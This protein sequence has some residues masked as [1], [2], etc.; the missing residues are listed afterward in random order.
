MS[1]RSVGDNVERNRSSANLF[2][3][4]DTLISDSELDQQLSPSSLKEI[5]KH[6][7]KPFDN[8][9]TCFNQSCRKQ[10]TTLER[11]HHCRRCGGIFCSSCL[12]FSRRLNKLAK[13]DPDGEW[14]KVCK[15][16][17]ELGQLT[18]GQTRCHTADFC[19]LRTEFKRWAAAEDTLKSLSWRSKLDIDRECQRL[20][21]GFEKNVGHSELKRTLHGVKSFVTT[22][23]WMKSSTW[24]RED[25]A[26]SCQTCNEVFGITKQK[27]FCHVC[28]IAVCKSCSSNDLIIYIPDGEKEEQE[29]W[30]PKLAIIKIIGCPQVEPEI[31]WPLRVCQSCR[32]ILEARQIQ[33]Y[34][35]E[36]NPSVNTADFLDQLHKLR[37]TFQ[38]AENRV[39]AQLPK[40]DEIVNLL[41]DSTRA[42]SSN[43]NVKMLAKAQGDLA[44]V[45]AQYVSMVQQ[46][47][48]L[49]PLTETQSLLLKHFI[50]GKCDF[51]LDQM[52]AFRRLK[53]KLS[54]SVTSE[55]LDL[56]QRIMDKNAIISTHLYLRQLVYETI[57]LCQKYKIEETL[58]A[59]LTKIEQLVE[60]DVKDC[61]KKE[62]DDV[63]KHMQLVKESIKNSL[64]DKKL[65]C[66]SQ[67]QLRIN[68]VKHVVE[69]MHLR[70]ETVLNQV[71]NELCLRSANRSYQASK[72]S[73]K[74]SLEELKQQKGKVA[75]AN[76][77]F[78]FVDKLEVSPDLRDSERG[79]WF[80]QT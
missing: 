27:N 42:S 20:L 33:A 1:L 12:E 49:R 32:R 30:P 5:T 58:P 73:L 44:D 6:H 21:K 37:E 78:V 68:G 41:E 53:H 50:K 31:C 7:W 77:D 79:S 76:S 74:T 65:I 46:L 11:H 4:I 63:E 59:F 36:L 40:Y 18:D 13:P 14:H 51:Y 75:E 43:N 19:A 8:K 70:V 66:L 67:Q 28:G 23:D 25:L 17:F 80:H 71:N 34:E 55:S 48:K 60:S 15:G 61:L 45:L 69:M 39:R 26:K 38:E 22:P 54:E 52:S 64:Q 47:K 72:A 9:T 56:I 62:K 57:Y 2:K 29:N 10:F 35:E 3:W 24:I 16:C